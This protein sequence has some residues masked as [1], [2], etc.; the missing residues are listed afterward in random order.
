[1]TTGHSPAELLHGRTILDAVKPDLAK[2]VEGKQFERK[3]QHDH[4]S[5]ERLFAVQDKVYVQ[6]FGQGRPWLPG[7]LLGKGGPFSFMS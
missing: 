5:K 7:Y 1:M 4:R 3:R 2:T 6:N